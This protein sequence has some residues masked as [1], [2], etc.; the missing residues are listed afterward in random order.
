MRFKFH[1]LFGIIFLVLLYFLFS[2]II[3]FWGLLIIF[4]SSF[5]IDIDHYFYYIYK[6]GDFSL[7]R[8]Y[9]WYIKNAHK[10][11][12]LSKEKRKQI[13]LGFYIFH[14]IEP[15]IILF[16]LGLYVSQ[17]FNFVLIGFLFHLSTDLISEI[18]L[19]QRIDKVFLIQN[20]II[21]RKL[22]DLEEIDSD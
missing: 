6:K 21:T 4:L 8:A 11:Y 12:F 10:F 17:F 2:S 19:K 16:F 14:G 3:S 9:K 13:Y 7:V 1:F 15:L 20:Y 5:L 18:I 22:T